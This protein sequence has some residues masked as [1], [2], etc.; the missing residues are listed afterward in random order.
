MHRDAVATRG[1]SSNKVKELSTQ[2]GADL[3]GIASVKAFADAPSGHHPR[4]VLRGARSVI[5]MAVA[6]PRAALE[7]A[8]SFEYSAS[9]WSANNELDRI[10]F[11]VAKFLEGNGHRAVQIPAS[12]PHDV[13]HMTGHLSHKHAGELAGLG[14]F[15]KNNLLLSPEYGS[16][17]RLVSVITDAD[18][19]SDKR[20]EADFCSDCDE[21]IR[22]CPAKAL[23]GNRRVDKKACD[24][25]EFRIGQ[26]FDPSGGQQPCGVCIRVCPVGSSDRAFD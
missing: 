6:L 10:A 18:L 15:G 21:C 4:D 2:L 23:K 1:I 12:S 13:R 7:S 25:R 19:A 17:M 26:K 11:R 14:V 5:V 9:Y 22:A 3:V 16:R 24:D 20:L 8:P